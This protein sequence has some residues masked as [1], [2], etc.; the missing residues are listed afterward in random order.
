[1]AAAYVSEGDA[2]AAPDVMDVKLTNARNYISVG[3]YDQAM[4]L[5]NE[6]SNAGSPSQKEQARALMDQVRAQRG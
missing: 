3:A 2:V 4:R 6:V 5:I 1:M